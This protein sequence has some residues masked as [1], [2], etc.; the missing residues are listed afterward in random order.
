MELKFNIM[1][2]IQLGVEVSIIPIYFLFA[3]HV[4]KVEDFDPLTTGYAYLSRYQ[5]QLAVFALA[6]YQINLGMLAMGL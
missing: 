1:F 4:L 6:V 3:K 2:L 5:V